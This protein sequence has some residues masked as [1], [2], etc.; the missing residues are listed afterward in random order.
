MTYVIT[1]RCCADASCVPVC[2]VDCIHPTPGEPQF[3]TTEQL[4]IDPQACI[5][6]SAC[7]EACPVD[8][9]GADDQLPSES[10]R[11]REINE[12]YY[13]TELR[14]QTALPPR[15]TGRLDLGGLK[16]AIVGSGPAG[17]YAAKAILEH[18]HAEIDVYERN[19]VPHGL[20]RYG[21]APDHQDTK[22]IAD[23]F[24]FHD[25]RLHLGIEVGKHVTHDELLSFHHAVIY[26]T[27]AATARRLNIPG[28]E[29]PGS[30]SARDFVAWY[31]GEPAYAGLEFDLRTQRAVVIGNGNVALDIARIL[32][33][34]P[35]ALART[36]IADSALTALRASEIEE[37]VVLGRRELDQAAYSTS[38]FL[39]V[40]SRADIDVVM[41]PDALARLERTNRSCV[42][43]E[44]NAL[45]SVRLDIARKAAERQPCATNRR[46]TFRYLVTPQE[47]LGDD[48]VIGVRV[49]RSEP[50]TDAEGKIRARPTEVHETIAT[51]LVL[52]SLGS[53][54]SAIPGLP[55]N[56]K[57][58]LIPNVAG[59]VID[60]VTHAKVAGAYVSGWIKRGAT[61]VIGTN[62]ACAA[63]TVDQLLADYR[64]GQLSEPQRDTSALNGFLHTRQPDHISNAGWSRIDS[65]ER[66]A[67][68]QQGRPR[69][70]FT[71]VA[72]LIGAAGKRSI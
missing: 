12:A 35:D 17:A 41:D 60:P 66:V 64:A 2:P 40:A 3:A 52:A 7:V 28:T 19:F 59:R 58:G 27:G 33:T 69:V 71:A 10:Q 15:R 38:A 8:A 47:I 1:G 39:G 26:A 31:N 53:S 56:E 67:G 23:A 20:I 14:P 37:V 46:I 55:F 21:V 34:N 54:G 30:H 9:I 68:A 25:T 42:G 70:K 32:A 18:R 16:V 36:D 13:A 43:A 6:C 44:A 11:F 63:E 5:E 29:L 57:T 24:S 61:G 62:R 48:H 45:S 72:D 65:A 49:V 22:K 51:G 50:I 4:Y